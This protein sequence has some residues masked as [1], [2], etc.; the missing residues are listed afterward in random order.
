MRGR[1]RRADRGHRAAG[2]RAG[3]GADHHPGRRR[4]P[5][6]RPGRHPRARQRAR[7]D[8]V[9]GL[10]LGH[11]G[12]RRRRDHHHP[13]H[14]AQLDPADRRRGRPRGQAQGGRG[15]GPRRR[16]LLGRRHPRERRRA[17]RP[18][19]RRRVRLQV[20]PAPLRGGRVPPPEQR[21]ARPVPGGACRLPGA[22][23]GPRRGLPGGGAGA[24]GPRRALRRLPPVPAP[25]V[26]ERGR[27]P[28]H[29][30]RPLD[31]RPGARAAPVVLGRAAHAGQ[32][33]P[34]R[35]GGQRRDLPP[36]PDLR[37][38]DHR[39][40]GHPVQVLPAHPRGREPR[41]A[42]ARAWPRA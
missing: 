11:Q 2:G 34:R 7:P 39:R 18:A 38:R 33:P 27:G 19:R 28:R 23:A 13:R 40:R 3:R 10:R 42:L 30:E 37:R 20:L 32:R 17:A 24:V 26:R 12:R 21:R 4:G 15:P 22:A 41:A 5:A 9:G 16:R 36:L 1:P 31:R 8:R 14:A 25:R 35:G 6:A 29:R